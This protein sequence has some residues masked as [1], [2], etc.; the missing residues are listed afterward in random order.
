MAA[1]VGLTLAS[2]TALRLI[3]ATVAFCEGLAA[4]FL[5]VVGCTLLTIGLVVEEAG[6]V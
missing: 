4:G 3:E 5:R 1:R 2:L 6:L